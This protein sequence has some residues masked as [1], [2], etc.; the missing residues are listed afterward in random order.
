V[1]VSDD[2]SVDVNVAGLAIVISAGGRRAPEV[3]SFLPV[4]LRLHRCQK[5]AERSGVSFHT[6]V[7]RVAVEPSAALLDLTKSHLQTHHFD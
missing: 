2:C 3:V 7:S 5:V 1:V 4:A 6:E